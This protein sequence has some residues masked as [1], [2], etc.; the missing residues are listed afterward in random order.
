MINIRKIAAMMLVFVMSVGIAFA[1]D[2]SSADKSIAVKSSAGESSADRYDVFLTG[3][4]SKTK[5][6]TIIELIHCGFTRSESTSM[7]NSLDCKKPEHVLIARQVTKTRANEINEIFMKVG[8]TTKTLLHDK[9]LDK[10]YIVLKSVN[11]HRRSETINEIKN[12]GYT[13]E[14]AERLFDDYVAGRAWSLTLIDS[15]PRETA[16][17]IHERFRAVG[18]STNVAKLSLSNTNSNTSSQTNNNTSSQSN[19]N[20]SSQT[21]NNASSQ[22]NNNAS[23]QTNNNTSS[24]TNSNT[25]SQSNSNTSYQPQYKVILYKVDPERRTSTLDALK[26][27]GK[28]E[29]EALQIWDTVS[30]GTAYGFYYLS[31]QTASLYQS[32]LKNAGATVDI[33]DQHGGSFATHY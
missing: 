1:A 8:A 31:W 4:D 14:R 17:E 27:C 26:K 2:K 7:F 32:Y 11:S 18:A 21:N 19:S 30:H 16:W 33:A 12:C 20:T 22:S 24:Q 3:V 28:S 25:S 9:K 6:S 29:S 5:E 15:L 13:D 23:S 10:W